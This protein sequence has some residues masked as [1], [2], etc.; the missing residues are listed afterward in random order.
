MHPLIGPF[1]PQ[2]SSR[3]ILGDVPYNI[4]L[5]DDI[6]DLQDVFIIYFFQLFVN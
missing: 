4:G 5:V 6:V 3:A 2:R 1:I